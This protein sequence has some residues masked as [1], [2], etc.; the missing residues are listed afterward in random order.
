MP[1]RKTS[2]STWIIAG[3]ALAMVI[4][5]ILSTRPIRNE[6]TVRTPRS[7]PHEH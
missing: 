7:D 1:D 4:I 2:L 6:E 5:A 3:I